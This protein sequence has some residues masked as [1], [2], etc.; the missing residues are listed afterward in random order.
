MRTKPIFA[1]RARYGFFG[2]VASK[3]LRLIGLWVLCE[4]KLA[5]LPQGNR[6]N[7]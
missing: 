6:A 7:G 2:R 1:Q 3:M 4:D 5:G